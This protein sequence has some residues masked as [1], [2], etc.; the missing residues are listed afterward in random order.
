M[1][2]V[3]EHVPN[4]LEFKDELIRIGKRGYIELPTKF[5]DNLVFG[6]DEEVL[7][8]K[9]WFEF[10]DDRNQLLYTKKV[11]PMEKFISVATSWK[12][13][14]YFEDSFL[15]QF[16]WEDS[17]KL[18]E[19]SAFILEKKISFFQ[20]VKKYISKKIRDLFKH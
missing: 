9:W 2:H 11:D 10:N 6:S 12:F 17:F 8:H 20:I 1:S 18:E 16:Y 4:L 14:K 13:Q 5:Y 19:R 15:L 7:G 3:L